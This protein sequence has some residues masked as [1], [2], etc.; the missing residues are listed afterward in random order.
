MFSDHIQVP[1]LLRSRAGVI[2][3][4]IYIYI[5]KHVYMHVY[6]YTYICT[7]IYIHVSLLKSLR[8]SHL[9]TTLCLLATHDKSNH[10]KTI[11][12]RTA[13]RQPEYVNQLNQPALPYQNHILWLESVCCHACSLPWET[14]KAPGEPPHMHPCWIVPRGRCTVVCLMRNWQL[15]YV[16]VRYLYKHAC[17][18]GSRSGSAL[19]AVGSGS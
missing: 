8:S 16:S 17:E 9:T 10:I 14:Q 2:Y 18:C 5:Y 7:Y 12:V 6:M 13:I 4:Y 3:I 15:A 11:D 1:F 19:P